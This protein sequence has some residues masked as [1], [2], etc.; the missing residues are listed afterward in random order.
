MLTMRHTHS[1]HKNY[2]LRDRSEIIYI[3]GNRFKG[4]F[5]EKADP[6]KKITLILLSLLLGVSMAAEKKILVVYYS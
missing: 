1:G 5:T 6:M 2:A 4:I 3:K